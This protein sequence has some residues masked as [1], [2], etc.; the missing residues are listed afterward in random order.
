MLLPMPLPLLPPSLGTKKPITRSYVVI[1]KP[2]IGQA[3]W[4]AERVQKG[5]AH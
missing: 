5:I 1:T 2:K 4:I 3:K